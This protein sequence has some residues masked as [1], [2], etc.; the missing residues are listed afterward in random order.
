MENIK[1]VPE[2]LIKINYLHSSPYQ[3]NMP[4]DVWLYS[5]IYKDSNWRENQIKKPIVSAGSSAEL[6]VLHYFFKEKD[7]KKAIDAGLKE[8]KKSKSFYVGG[9]WQENYEQVLDEM[10]QVIMQGIAAFTELNLDLNNAVSQ[11][12]CQHYLPGI[13]FPIT[14]KSDFINDNYVVELKTRRRSP[15]TVKKLKNGKSPAWR[16]ASI[17][18]KP[19]SHWLRQVSFYALATGKEPIL[20]CVNDQKYKIYDQH[21]CSL[22]QPERIKIP[23]KQFQIKNKV[24]QNWLQFSTNPFVLAKIISPDFSSYYWNDL[25]DHEF[26]EAVDLWANI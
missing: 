10:P 26:E 23:L 17:P 25:D 12:P 2:H 5:Y 4:D 22:L 16:T 24:R 6:G 8:F 20:V 9:R 3:T 14:G 1:T 19:Y 15:P 13:D 21:N 7:N 11:E 18:E